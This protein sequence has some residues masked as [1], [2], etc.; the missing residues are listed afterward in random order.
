MLSEPII[1][2]RLRIALREGSSPPLRKRRIV[3]CHHQTSWNLVML[4][5]MFCVPQLSCWVPCFAVLAAENSISQKRESRIGRELQ[6]KRASLMSLRTHPEQKDQ[7]PTTIAAE[8]LGQEQREKVRATSMSESRPL[9]RQALEVVDRPI[10][11]AKVAA[12]ESSDH[13]LSEYQRFLQSDTSSPIYELSS[14]PSPIFSYIPNFL[15]NDPS[16]IPSDI[17]TM[18]PTDLVTAPTTT[19]AD[20]DTPSFEPSRIPT[21]VSAV[22]V[23]TE[24][25]TTNDPPSSSP[26]VPSQSPVSV[27]PTSPDP[28]FSQTLLPTIRPTEFVT[29]PPTTTDDFDT[30]TFK[31]STIPTTVSPVFITTESPTTT[32]PTSS[33]SLVPWQSPVTVP[34]SP[35]PSFSPTPIPTPGPTMPD[36]THSP[37][38]V[39][40]SVPTS[41]DPSFSPTPIPT[42]GPTMPDPTH[43]PTFVLSTPF[44][45]VSVTPRPTPFPTPPPTPEP[46]HFPTPG[47]N[48]LPSWSPT[49]LPTPGPTTPGPTYSPTFGLSTPF[50]SVSVASGPTPFPTPPPTPGPTDFPTLGS[51]PFPSKFPLRLPTLGPTTPAVTS[52]PTFGLSTPFPFGTERPVPFPTP[53]PASG[54]TISPT[55]GSTPFSSGFSTPLPTSG[56]MTSAPTN[57]PTFAPNTPYPSDTLGPVP[58]PTPPPAPGTTISPTPGSTPFSSGFSTPLP[59]SGP[60]TSAPTNP[61]TFAPNTPYPSDTLG[62]VPSPTP[63]PASGTTISP[64]PGSTP[65]SSGF[66]T[67]LPT[68][69]PMTSAPT[70]SPKAPTTPN[71]SGS[72]TPEIPFSTLPP[73]PG[74]APSPTPPPSPGLTNSPLASSTMPPPTTSPTPGA[75]PFPTEF[76]T[77]APTSQY[78]TP[79]TG[80]TIDPSDA[81]I[82]LPTRL[83]SS[84][85]S[86]S[87]STVTAGPT[88]TVRTFPLESPS[89]IAPSNTPSKLET[90]WSGATRPGFPSSSPP[91]G[92]RTGP[93]LTPT[94]SFKFPLQILEQKDNRAYIYGAASP[95]TRAR[96]LGEI[97]DDC[98]LFVLDVLK[99]RIEGEIQSADESIEWLE[100]AMLN[101][102]R[103]YDVAESAL[104]YTLDVEIRVRTPTVHESAERYLTEGFSSQQDQLL[105]LTILKSSTNCPL[106]ANA[107]GFAFIITST[108]S[109]GMD[110]TVNSGT[111]GTVLIAAFVAAIAAGAILTAI[112]VFRRL[113]VNSSNRTVSEV[114]DEENHS[115]VRDHEDISEIGIEAAYEVSTLGDPPIVG[116]VVEPQE[117]ATNE[118]FSLNYDYKPPLGPHTN[119]CSSLSDDYTAR[120][121]NFVS[122]DDATLEAQYVSGEQFEVFAPPGSLGLILD[123]NSDG[124]PVVTSVKTTSVLSDTVQPGDRLLAVDGLDVVLMIASDISRI[125]A[126][127]KDQPERHFLFLRPAKKEM[128]SARSLETK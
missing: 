50:P 35:D 77:R 54:T 23:G 76:P 45:S 30:P 119:S 98:D 48:P 57:P 64:T 106:F 51:T 11:I 85:P 69:G 110:P 8:T 41:P 86:Y 116:P 87:P 62:P 70:N 21:A 65:F 81:P 13:T 68:S 19:T 29:T 101:P 5:S 14:S 53:P 74:P 60:M 42:P 46:T 79:T 104:V 122:K 44:P 91:T 108:S 61:P 83:P 117:T 27:V 55:P 105:V 66:L 67:P 111:Q 75:T 12:E 72:L 115:H 49:P 7:Q 113:V 93:T 92:F 90:H 20:F 59:T 127:K 114:P 123:T 124:V 118:S 15:S 47:S 102:S 125:I 103:Y 3:K 16:D 63:P 2:N 100:V 80:P 112:F 10:A 40:V 97:G 84:S 31:P 38:F 36:P 78:P 32:A 17:P 120:S 34:T 126:L 4:M 6:G 1:S 109:L 22:V 56:P 94:R 52:S 33:P 95:A 28:S 24:S 89:S 37:T 58:S 39:P 88:I 9:R 128:N 82:R 18:R 71:P 107:F 26:L 99:A 43:S 121:N 73:T 25:P 96:S